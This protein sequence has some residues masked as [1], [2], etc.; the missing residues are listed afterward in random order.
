VSSNNNTF[1]KVAIN[2]CSAGLGVT[3]SFNNFYEV[4][5]NKTAADDSQLG[6]WGVT[7][8]GTANSFFALAVRNYKEGAIVAGS[9]NKITAM[10]VAAGTAG[11]IQSAD[12]AWGLPSV[13]TG[14]THD[15]TGMDGKTYQEPAANSIGVYFKAAGLLSYS[16]V[17]G[18]AHGVVVFANNV[19]IQRNVA[20]GGS[21]GA[22][23]IASDPTTEKAFQ[24]TLVTRNNF[25]TSET[26][27]YAEN[28]DKSLFKL[29]G[30]EWMA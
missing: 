13:I 17:D 21:Q 24:P 19:K 20:L 25:T 9:N 28:S 23:V 5:I 18:F 27:V 26:I 11:A 6:G 14:L 22:V 7:S 1:R 30:V 3:G 29:F 10:Q 4:A 15:V 2:E 16:K 8:T 12:G